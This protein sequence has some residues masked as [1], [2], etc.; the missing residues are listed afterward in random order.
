MVQ[1]AGSVFNAAIFTTNYQDGTHAK[2]AGGADKSSGNT[3]HNTKYLAAGTVSLNGAG[4]AAVNTIG[5][6]DCP[7]LINFSH[8]VAVDITDHFV[9]A[10]DG[11]NT[12]NPPTDV[13]FQIAEQGDA[14][15][16]GAGG[17]GAALGVT[18]SLAAASHDF[19]FL[20]SASPDTVGQKTAFRIRDELIYS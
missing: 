7:L 8:G 4:S 14:A 20:I 19:F 11:A 12:A 6:A 10:Y 13:T 3:P 16:T 9:Y 1:F 2:T 5:T 15:W 17:S 18:D